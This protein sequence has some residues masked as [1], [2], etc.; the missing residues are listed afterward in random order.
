[1]KLRFLILYIVSLERPFTE[2]AVLWFD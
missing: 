2:P 1:M